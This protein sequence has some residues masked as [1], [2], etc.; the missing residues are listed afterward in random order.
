L[1]LYR[2][3]VIERGQIFPVDMD[4]DAQGVRISCYSYKPGKRQEAY[5]CYTRII[6]LIKND[7]VERNFGDQTKRQEEQEKL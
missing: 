7:L 2:K 3:V 6:R 5:S 4:Q 1:D